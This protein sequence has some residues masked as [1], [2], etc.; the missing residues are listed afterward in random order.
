MDIP[1]TTEL[2]L[3]GWSVIL[4]LVHIAFQGG[5]A[6]RERGLRWDAGARDEGPPP[7]GRHARRAQRA[8]SQRRWRGSC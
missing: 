7:L 8:P 1:V 4:L 5:L 2:G 6:L 3:L